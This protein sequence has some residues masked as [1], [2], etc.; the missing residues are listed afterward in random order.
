MTTRLSAQVIFMPAMG[1]GVSGITSDEGLRIADGMITLP[2]A[3]DACV[4]TTDG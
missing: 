3:T 1:S 2:D 4:Y